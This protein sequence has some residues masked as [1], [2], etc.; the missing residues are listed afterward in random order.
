MPHFYMS[1][2]VNP[3]APIRV[4]LAIP[5]YSGLPGRFVFSLWHSQYEL[6]SAGIS[7][8]L[9]VLEEHCHVDD[10]RNSL[11]R[12]FLESDCTDLIFLDADIGWMEGNLNKLL[13]SDKDI[14]GGIYPLKQDFPDFPI[15]VIPGDLYAD[16][17]GCVEVL[18]VP[19]GFLKIRRHVLQKLYDD[20]E[21]FKGDKDI[22]ERIPMGLIFERDLFKGQRLGGDY[23]FCRKAKL[24]GF[25]IHCMPDLN[26]SHMGMNTWNGNLG[27]YWKRQNGVTQDLF[28]EAISKIKLGTETDG[29]I[30]NI[31][32][33][34][35][36]IPNAAGAGLITEWIKEARKAT[37]DVMECGSGITT[38][39]AAAA[40]PD[41]T[42]WALDHDMDWAGKTKMYA[43]KYNLGNIEVVYAPL[44][45]LWYDVPDTYPKVFS[46]AL[47]DG[48]PRGFSDRFNITKSGVDLSDAVV[49]WDDMDYG[50]MR[51]IVNEFAV[52]ND[53]VAEFIEHESKDYAVVR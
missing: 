11:V 20:S 52:L 32:V 13:E 15:R 33:H 31:C 8:D 12:Q 14:V 28:D 4:F 30:H 26:F 19:T 16:E 21:K 7:V 25:K 27:D 50:R 45:N 22:A 23:N 5:A 35:G 39:V 18:G 2:G 53:S 3:L 40:N 10:A 46:L 29:D 44:K 37:G 49:I 51:D 43:E 17:D 38:L 6:N 36:N 41:I 1:T 24:A 34:W 9:C 42:V 48:P 47:V